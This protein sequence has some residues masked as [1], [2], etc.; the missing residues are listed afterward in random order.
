MPRHEVLVRYRGVEL[1]RG[2]AVVRCDTHETP[3]EWTVELL[4]SH[5]ELPDFVDLREHES[6]VHVEVLEGEHASG[7]AFVGAIT[8]H[9]SGGGVSLAG[10]GYCPVPDHRVS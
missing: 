7:S 10:A 4:L 6:P 8:E 9:G 1:F 3:H 2:S 5:E